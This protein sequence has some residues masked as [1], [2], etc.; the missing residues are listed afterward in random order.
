[1]FAGSQTNKKNW[2]GRVIEGRELLRK[3]LDE[4]VKDGRTRGRLGMG[5]ID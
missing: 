1:M 5:I 2:I 3:V 4:G